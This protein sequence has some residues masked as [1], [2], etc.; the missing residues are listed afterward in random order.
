M[1][2][3]IPSMD[4]WLEEAR[5]DASASKVGMYLS[6]IGVVRQTPKAQ[7][8]E[9]KQD[10]GRVRGM[11]FSYDAE[12]IRKAVDDTYKLDG[13]YYVKVWLNSGYLNV[14]DDI[15]R[16]LVGGDIRPHVADALQSLVDR[17]KNELVVEEEQF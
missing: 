11:N 6:H 17:I 5:K 3:G 8:R 12:G 16:V 15:M 10:A 14:G 13:I 1:A 4:L 9:G 2:A 7:V